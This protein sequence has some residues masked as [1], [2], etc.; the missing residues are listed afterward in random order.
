MSLFLLLPLEAP[1]KT[2]YL[3]ESATK[4]NIPI[5]FNN[6]I[7]LGTH[8][9]FLPATVKGVKAGV[10]IL[11]LSFAEV[12]FILPANNDI[13]PEDT[14]V[15]QFRLGGSSIE[16]AIALYTAL[17]YVSNNDGVVFDSKSNQYFSAEQLQHNIGVVLEH[18]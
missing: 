10:E 5:I 13:N 2:E 8:S 11:K 12:S 18:A 17:V 16:T 6:G 3:N 9:G 14:L 4:L 15:I 7:D 1:L